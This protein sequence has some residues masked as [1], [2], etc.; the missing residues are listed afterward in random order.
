MVDKGII[1]E[2][3]RD[4][5]HWLW[6]ARSAIHI[7]EIDHTEHQKYKM[8]EYNRAIKATRELRNSLAEYHSI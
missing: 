1:S 4:E 8:S 2:D 6:E 7:Y 3:L 5:L